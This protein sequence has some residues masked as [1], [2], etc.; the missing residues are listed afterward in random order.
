MHSTAWALVGTGS[1]PLKRLA[2]C[3]EQLRTTDG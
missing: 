1:E 3:L 2:K